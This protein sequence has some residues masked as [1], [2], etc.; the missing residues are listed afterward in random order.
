MGRLTGRDLTGARNVFLALAALSSSAVVLSQGWN[1]FG[2]YTRPEIDAWRTSLARET[3]EYRSHH[4]MQPHAGA[5]LDGDLTLLRTE[6]EC[7]FLE[8]QI[9]QLE[10]AKARF[11][12]DQVPV[13]A[14]RIYQDHLYK[15]RTRHDFKRCAEVLSP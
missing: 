5:A 2:W 6:V 13:E 7:N 15:K 8:L 11:E 1:A 4:E 12:T 3:A 14:R 9:D 10:R